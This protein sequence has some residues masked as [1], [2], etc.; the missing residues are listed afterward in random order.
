[1][2]T[3]KNYE[4]IDHIVWIPTIPRSR[5]SMTAGILARS[6]AFFGKVSS[7]KHNDRGL[8][9]NVIVNNACWGERIKDSG[10]LKGLFKLS[11]VNSVPEDKDFKDIFTV[12][13]N[14]HGYKKGQTAVFK[15]APFML[16]HKEIMECFPNSTWLI[17]DRNKEDR[18][19]S[20]FKIFKL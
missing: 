4:E 15:H 3:F 13:M 5:S 1:M 9:E 14:H 11:K 6:G 20:M 17:P 18:L 19:D 12:L 10:G 2:I 8:Y 7:G 16:F